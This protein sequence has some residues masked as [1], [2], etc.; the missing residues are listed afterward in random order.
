M[1]THSSRDLLEHEGIYWYFEHTDGAHKLVLVDSHSAHDS[2]P[3][4]ATLR[5]TETAGSAT[6]GQEYLTEWTFS[7]SVQTG[8]SAL[9]SYDFERPSTALGVEKSQARAYALSDYEGFDFQGDYTQKA[10]GTQ[11]VENRLDEQQCAV[12]QAHARSNALGLVVGHTMKMTHHPRDDQNAAYLVTALNVQ[13]RVGVFDSQSD[14][15]GF[16]CDLSAIPAGQQF[17]PARRTP[18][19]FVQGPQTAIVVG[20]GGDEI[21]TD[22]YGRVKVQFHWDR[23]GGKNDKSSCWVRV[24]SPWAGKNFGVIQIPRIGQEVVVGFLEGDP[25]QPLVTGR[26]HNAEQMPPW[27]LPANATQ[28]GILTRSSKGG[29]A[30]NANVLRF[31]DKKGSEQLL[32]HAEKKPGHRSRKRRDALDRARPQQDGRPRRDRGGQ[33]RPHRDRGDTTNRSR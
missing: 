21:H 33:A 13:A 30:A 3:G 14:A 16:A 29:S 28:S 26:V 12:Q 24:S 8:K 2:A 1:T 20:P 7:E 27:D 15:H 22:K 5:Y 17:R 25:D 6:P 31:E 11:Y 19:P 23:L 10:D 9:T 18:K 4:Y 32:I